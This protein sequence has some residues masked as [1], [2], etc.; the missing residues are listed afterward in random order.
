MTLL[1]QGSQYLV[2]GLLQLLLDWAVFVLASALGLAAPLANL[3]GRSSGAL[4][5]YWLN[6]RYTFA[7]AHGSRLGWAVFARFALLWLLMTTL[8]TAALGLIA[9]HVGLGWAWL[10]KPAVELGL[11]LANFFLMRRLVYR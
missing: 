7:D 11:A 10:A 6:G 3:A 1:R 9:H 8:S 5:G 2:I 4:A